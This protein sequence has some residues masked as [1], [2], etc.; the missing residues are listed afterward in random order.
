M[1]L[2]NTVA[3]AAFL[4]TTSRTADAFGPVVPIRAT[5]FGQSSSSSSTSNTPVSNAGNGASSMTMRIGTQDL[6]RKQRVLEIIDSNLSSA[7][8]VQEVLLSE[9][10]SQLIQ[11]CNWKTRNGLIRKVKNQAE[12]YGITIDPSFGIP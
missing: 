5:P 3:L 7:E 11:K 10:M 2:V 12:R 9:N 1:R 6:N 4:A 8:S